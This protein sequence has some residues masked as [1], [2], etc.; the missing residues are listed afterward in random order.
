MNITRYG[1][2]PTALFYADDTD[3]VKLLL[4]S[5]S[6]INVKNN[7]GLNAL[8]RRLSRKRRKIGEFCL[9]LFAAGETVREVGN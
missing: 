4:R 2:V 6:R 3:S 8:E 5:G 7:K 9:V 1:N